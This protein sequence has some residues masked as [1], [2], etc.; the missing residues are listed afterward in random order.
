MDTLPG[1]W[2]VVAVPPGLVLVIALAADAPG[3]PAIA[4]VA[5]PVASIVAM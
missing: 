3:A 2:V 4:A 5:A 1:D